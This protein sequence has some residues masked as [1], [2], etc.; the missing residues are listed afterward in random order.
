M[1]ERVLRFLCA[2][3]KCVNVS[4][5]NTTVPS[6]YLR[7]EELRR[8]L[9]LLFFASQ[10][11][12]INLLTTLKASGL[13]PAQF[14]ALYFIAHKQGVNVGE[15]KG[16]LSI[17]N[18]SLHRLLN[19]L[20]NAELIQIARDEEDQRKRVLTTTPKGQEFVVQIEQEQLKLIAK[21]YRTVGPEAVS[22]FWNVLKALGQ[23]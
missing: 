23:P 14:H 3:F 18:Q 10:N 17:S 6:L 22:G 5:Q 13:G 4:D 8:G 7:E 12:H 1:S 2:S 16:L 20:S 11:M 19:A 9:D 15:L 21:A